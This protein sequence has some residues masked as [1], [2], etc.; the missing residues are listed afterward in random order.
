MTRVAVL[1]GGAG[2]HAVAAECT[3]AGHS[4]T[5]CEA[6]EFAA[7]IAGIR[8]TRTVQVLGRGPEP[9]AAK[10]AGVT[11]DVAEAVGGADLIFIVVPCFGHEPMA[12]ACAPHLRDGQT[13]VFLGEGSGAL[14]MR[15]V[16]RD[17]GARADVLI[18]ETNTLPYLTR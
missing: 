5:L 7:T 2:G 8:D 6:P 4:V 15:Q 3:W 18:G 17:A 14:V 16:L 13:V 10:L 12:R 1:G 11:T 9:V